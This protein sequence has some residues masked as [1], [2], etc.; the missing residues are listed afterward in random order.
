MNDESGQ[1]MEPMEEMLLVGLSNDFWGTGVRQE[2]K[3]PTVH[4]PC[5]I[6]R[7][8]CSS[9]PRYNIRITISANKNNEWAIWTF[10]RRRLLHSGVTNDVQ[11]CTGKPLLHRQSDNA[12][13]TR[14]YFYY[15]AILQQRHIIDCLSRPQ[16]EK[17]SKSCCASL[18]SIDHFK[19]LLLSEGTTKH[20]ID[21]LRFW[22]SSSRMAN[23]L[24][25]VAK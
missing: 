4:L 19:C 8:E 25:E 5:I 2:G 6:F 22:L 24:R 21:A 3:C 16:N 7:S 10:I 14:S 20:A 23:D 17:K 9:P 15:R 12:L 11:S 18:H 1:S 13:N